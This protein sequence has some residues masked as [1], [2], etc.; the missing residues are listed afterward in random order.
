MKKFL[1]ALLILAL[2]LPVCLSAG[3]AANT[4]NRDIIYRYITETMGYN[5]A[6]AV[7]ILSNIRSESNYSTESVGDSG[8]SFGICQWHGS[9]GEAMKKYCTDNGFSLTEIYGEKGYLNG[10]LGYLAYEL[11]H[12]RVGV[13][14]F[15]ATVPDTAQGAFDAAYKFCVSFEVPS[16]KES[17]G[18]TRGTYAVN[19]L[20]TL[21][22]GTVDEYSIRFEPNGGSGAPEVC[23]KREGIPLTLPTQCPVRPGYAFMGWAEIADAKQADYQAGGSYTKN[24][25]AVLYA[26]WV[27]SDENGLLYDYVGER[28]RVTGYAGTSAQVTVPDYVGVYQVIGIAA[29]AFAGSQ[30]PL[31]VLVPET[32]LDIEDGAFGENVTIA[33]LPGSAAYN[34]AGDHHLNRQCWYPAGSTLTLPVEISMLEDSAFEGTAFLYADLSNTGLFALP[35]GCFRGSSLRQIHLSSQICYIADSA[36]PANVRIVAPQGSEAARFAAANGYDYTDG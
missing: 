16:N 27:K 35:E 13:G 20:Y 15:F 31:T 19:T 6:V 24:G 9:R 29:G 3:A 5:R 7:G 1:C 23:T 12:G 14:N 11:K 30:T 28:L 36:L 2:A 32:V 18:I 25:D 10:Q 33:A 21:Y 8:T 4:E 22:G 26:V 34:H 17:K